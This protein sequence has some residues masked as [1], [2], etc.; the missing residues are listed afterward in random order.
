MHTIS[1]AKAVLCL[2]YFTFLK[3][4]KNKL[5]ISLIITTNSLTVKIIKLTD[6]QG[7]CVGAC[8]TIIV[9]ADLDGTTLSHTTKSYRVNRPL[10]Y[11]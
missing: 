10:G 9:K 4:V 1:R 7:C 3:S 11:P 5:T 6:L 8:L 2:L